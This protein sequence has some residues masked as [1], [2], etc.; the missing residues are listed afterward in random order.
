MSTLIEK[1]TP[2]RCIFAC[3]LASSAINSGEGLRV[4]LSPS[5]NS[6]MMED[7]IVELEGKIKLLSADKP[8]Q[9]QSVSE[10]N[11]VKTLNTITEYVETLAKKLEIV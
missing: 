1:L 8:I 11:V 10:E 4:T 6:I 9:E 2:N 3:R 5:I 7:K